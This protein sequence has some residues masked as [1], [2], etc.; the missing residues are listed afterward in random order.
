M[1]GKVAQKNILE[2][3]AALSTHSTENKYTWLKTKN[4]TQKARY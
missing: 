4:K 1:K 3:T 2:G